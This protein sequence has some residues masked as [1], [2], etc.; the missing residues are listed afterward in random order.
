M[1]AVTVSFFRAVW[2][3][4]HPRM[5]L[6]TLLPFVLAVVLWGVALWF[7]LQ[8]AIDWLQAY[9]VAHDGF[10]IAGSLLDTVGLN[11]IRAVVVPLIAM[12]L[13]LPLMIITALVFISLFAMPSVERHVAVRH[14]PQLEKRRGGG[15]W[16][17]ARTAVLSLLVFFLLWVLT[18]PVA[19]I[20]PLGFVIHPLLWGWLTYRVMGYDALAAHADIQ[21]R[22][23]ILKR[24]RW[25]LLAIGTVTG[26]LGTAPTLL[27][28]GGVLSVVFFPFFAAV[29]IWLYVLFFIFSGLWFQHY[30]LSALTSYRE[31]RSASAGGMAVVIT[32]DTEES[33]WQ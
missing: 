29:A 15:I 28:L 2:S 6:L 22:Q 7:C 12:W 14:Y 33:A 1:H 26:V 10:R 23:E 32:E 19:I 31:E 8:P 30:C 25:P 4:M 21:E 27:W 11:A 5:L 3:Q 20:P 9:F 24:H 16:G 18:L 17:S 13:L